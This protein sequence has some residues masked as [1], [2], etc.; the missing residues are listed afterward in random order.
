MQALGKPLGATTSK[1]NDKGAP[2]EMSKIKALLGFAIMAGLLAAITASSASA[3]VSSGNG[4]AKGQGKAKVTVFTDVGEKVECKEAVGTWKLTKGAI[5]SE[6]EQ[7]KGA[8][9][10]DLHVNASNGTPKGWIGC[11]STIGTPTISECEL[12]V[13]QTAKG[14]TKALGS[15]I[16]GCTVKISGLCTLEVNP[17]KANEGLK[18]ILNENIKPESLLSKVNVVGISTKVSGICGKIPTGTN[19]SGEEKGEVTGVQLRQE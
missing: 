16:K 3:L 10:V 7:V 2:K 15:V 1:H 18:E 19:T 14:Q 8:E 9:N 13:K 5:G 4:T 12:Q 6:V 17:E 11:T